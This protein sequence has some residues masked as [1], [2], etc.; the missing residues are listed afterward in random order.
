MTFEVPSSSTHSAL[1]DRAVVA[2][3]QAQMLNG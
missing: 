2:T 1:L 3:L